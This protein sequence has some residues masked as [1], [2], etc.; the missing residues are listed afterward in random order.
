MLRRQIY[1]RE[2]LKDG[3]MKRSAVATEAGFSDQTHL[4]RHLKKACALTVT[5]G[6]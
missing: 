5:P 6:P 4:G 2:L 3:R 1:A